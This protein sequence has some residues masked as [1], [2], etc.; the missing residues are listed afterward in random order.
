MTPVADHLRRAGRLSA[1]DDVVSVLVDV[2]LQYPATVGTLHRRRR[3]VA[4][5]VRDAIADGEDVGCVARPVAIDIHHDGDVDPSDG[6]AAVRMGDDGGRTG[7]AVAAIADGCGEFVVHL[8][9]V[10]PAVAVGVE[11]CLDA[12]ASLRADDGCRGL[13]R[14][15]LR[16]AHQLGWRGADVLGGVDLLRI[17]RAVAV[18]IETCRKG[19]AAMDAALRVRRQGVHP[20]EAGRAVLAGGAVGDHRRGAIGAL[21]QSDTA[22]FDDRAGDTVL[23]GGAV[24]A[25]HRIAGHRTHR[26]RGEGEQLPAHRASLMV[27]HGPHA[28]IAAARGK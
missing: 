15:H 23:S 17:E 3:P 8:V 11:S 5:L 19:G 10:Q 26:Q 1:V 13:A 16:G 14:S 24:L 22:L 12:G 28:D 18:V 2:E 20:G 7:G 6:T 27:L 9:V 25:D 21:E 4:E